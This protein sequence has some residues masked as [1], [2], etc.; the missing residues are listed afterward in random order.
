MIYNISCRHSHEIKVYLLYT[1]SYIVYTMLQRNLQACISLDDTYI[2]SFLVVCLHW[3]FWS[4]L[5]G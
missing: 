2:S 3:M 1:L 4:L 5:G